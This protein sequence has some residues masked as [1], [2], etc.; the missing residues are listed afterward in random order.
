MATPKTK[1]PSVT[2]VPPALDDPLATRDEAIARMQRALR[3]YTVV[4]PLTNV[5]FHRWALD[6][7]AFRSGDIDTGFIAREFQPSAL[8]D[9]LAADVPLIAAAIAAVSRT[10]APAATPAGTAPSGWRAAGRREG[11]RG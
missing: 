10:H 11:L 8:D 5:A 7:P 2:P 6:H 9:G 4:G 3:E 1:T